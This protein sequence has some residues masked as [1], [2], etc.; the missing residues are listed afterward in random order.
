MEHIETREKPDL[1]RIISI[2]GPRRPLSEIQAEE[3]QLEAEQ[4]QQDNSEQIEQGEIEQSNNL[5][6]TL[7]EKLLD[8]TELRQIKVENPTLDFEAA[9]IHIQGEMDSTLIKLKSYLTRLPQADKKEKPT[10]L[11]GLQ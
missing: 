7:A 2:L 5:Q 4:T 11:S 6:E 9:V 1:T 3:A 10:Q 8:L